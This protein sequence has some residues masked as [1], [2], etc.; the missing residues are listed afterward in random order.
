LSPGRAEKATGLSGKAH[1]LAEKRPEKGSR[2]GIEA[3]PLRFHM[4]E[5]NGSNLFV[6]TLFID[7]RRGQD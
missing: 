2:H 3:R 6:P 4:I 5:V 1:T 7:L